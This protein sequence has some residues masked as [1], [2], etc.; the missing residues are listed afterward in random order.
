LEAQVAI[1]TFIER[2]RDATLTSAEWNG[3]INLGRLERL[4]LTF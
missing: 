2:F 4:S 1:G 3:R